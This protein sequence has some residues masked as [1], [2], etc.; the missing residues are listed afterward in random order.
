MQK[1]MNDFG[2]AIARVGHLLAQHLDQY[3]KSRNIRYKDNLLEDIMINNKDHV[4]RLLYY[5]PFG[6]NDD[7]VS[8]HRDFGA[9]TGLS[10][11]NI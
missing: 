7:W 11:P 9:I 3:V 10:C 5:V 8:W 4:F 1:A 6:R 2:N